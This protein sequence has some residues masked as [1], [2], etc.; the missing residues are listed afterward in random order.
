[1]AFHDK[2]HLLRMMK[3]DLGVMA[4]PLPISDEE[5]YQLIIL[6]RTLPT[7]SQVCPLIE[8][9]IMDIQTDAVPDREDPVHIDGDSTTINTLLRIPPVK[10]YRILGVASVRPHNRLSNLSMSSSFETLESYQ[11]LAQAQSL[12]DLSSLMIPPMTFEYKAPDKVRLYNNHTYTS[13]LEVEVKYEHH[14]ELFT[15]PD[16][17]RE[18]FY[19]LALLDAKSWFYTNMNQFS[20][21]E[22]AYGHVTLKNIEEWSGADD[23]RE[24]LLN[25]WD[26]T[27][28]MDQPNIFWI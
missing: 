18:S 15:I 28:H 6:D 20:E 21:F 9:V 13:K 23:K 25:N 27:Y 7:F 16:T 12:A 17:A 14:P 4:I 22:T 5:L 2:N 3:G 19:K 26:E 11:D 8:K 24:E 10:P 1:M